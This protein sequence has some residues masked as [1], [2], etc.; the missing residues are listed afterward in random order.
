MYFLI[1]IDFKNNTFKLTKRTN[2]ARYIKTMLCTNLD[3]NACSHLDYCYYCGGCDEISTS[4]SGFNEWA[5]GG[6][7]RRALCAE[8]LNEFLSISERNERD[9]SEG[10]KKHQ[11]EDFFCKYECKRYP[12][13]PC[14][15]Q[16][17]DGGCLVNDVDLPHHGCALQGFCILRVDPVQSR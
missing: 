4:C 14:C 7:N 11:P 17:A 6:T 1:L 13:S 2:V 8:G 16:Q 15:P 3:Y 12:R 5:G 9:A 10:G